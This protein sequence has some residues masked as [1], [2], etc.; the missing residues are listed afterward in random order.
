MLAWSEAVTLLTVLLLS[1]LLIVLAVLIL[2]LLLTHSL[3]NRSSSSLNRGI[4][5]TP[6]SKADTSSE[7]LVWSAF[8]VNR[9][10]L[11]VP[12]LFCS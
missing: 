8:G 5:N 1:T 12:P 6:Y 9:T 10:P 4:C 11:G 2:P 7:P 3:P